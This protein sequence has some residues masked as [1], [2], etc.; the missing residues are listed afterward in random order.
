VS[1][2]DLILLVLT[3]L[4]GGVA[5]FITVQLAKINGTFNALPKEVKQ[6]IVVVVAVAFGFATPD[7][8]MVKDALI[9]L[10]AFLL[11]R[12]QRVAA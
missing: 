7:P 10:A 1:I 6:A 12:T 2:P 9:A 8:G 11:H 4:A 5:T 3:A